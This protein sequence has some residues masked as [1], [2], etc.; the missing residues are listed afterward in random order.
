LRLAQK[1]LHSYVAENDPNDLQDYR[2]GLRESE[3]GIAALRRLMADDAPQ[4]DRLDRTE[5]AFARFA[6]FSAT[7]LQVMRTQGLPAAATFLEGHENDESAEATALL[8]TMQG[9]ELRKLEQS[10]RDLSSDVAVT[11]LSF[12]AAAVAV[13]ILQVWAFALSRRDQ[14]QRRA[15]EADLKAVNDRL[16]NRVRERTA[17]LARKN[18]LM[19]RETEQR[20]QVM[21]HLE[22]LS[23]IIDGTN[24]FVAVADA[25]GKLVYLNPAGRRLTGY[26]EGQPLDNLGIGDFQP[27]LPA[28]IA[29]GDI[30]LSGHGAPWFGESL[31]RAR[32]G[33]EIPVSQV[34]IGHR[35]AHGELLYFST[36]C[37][38]ISE[39]RKHTV[40]VEDYA[41]RLASTSRQILRVQEQ[42]RRAIAL[43]LHDQIGQQLAALKINLFRI[44]RGASDP[45]LAVRIGDCLE[46]TETTLGQVR[47]LALE[48]RPSVLDNLGLLPAL[49]WYAQHQSERADCSIE[50]VAAA[51]PERLDPDLVTAAFRIV[52]EAVNN[53]VRHGRARH[54]DITLEVVDDNLCIAV[55]DDGSGFDSRAKSQAAAREGESL[56]LLGMRE[57]CELVG[58]R[59]A[60]AS[61]PGQGTEVRAELPLHEPS[62]P[63]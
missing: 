46:I 57:R 49:E 2:V 12:E 18:Q 23:A 17:E 36:I 6:R 37:R 51:L 20:R 22:L 8:A 15:A 7:V 19:D 27:W 3:N 44:E 31:L 52:Q 55:R 33:R 42:E 47:G 30:P 4:L 50:V 59:F 41:R 24:D 58:G 14:Q 48:L 34:I 63:R 61:Q 53:A 39:S 28:R 40:I 60:I 5:K 56:G 11:Y 38:D 21:T 32:D 62:D 54:I 1:G 13:L 9:E 29:A 35:D 26:D 10:K 16:E 45:S 25:H 43:E